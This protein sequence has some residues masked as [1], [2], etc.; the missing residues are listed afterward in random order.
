MSVA[1]DAVVIGAGHNGLVAAILLA[2]AGWSVT[3]LERNGEPGGAV[4]TEEVTVPGFKHDLFAMSLNAFIG[5]SFFAEHK[6]ELFA[7]GLALSTSAKPFGSIFPDGT[8]V[9]VSTRAEETLTSVGAVSAS[10]AESWRR[11][12]A[13]FRAYAPHLFATLATP[14]PSAAAAL[15]VLGGVRALGLKWP[16]D[17]TRLAAQ[18]SREF[19]EE[20]FER[21]ELHALVASWGMHLDFAPDLPGG[22]LFA[23]L[24]A[25]L[26]AEHGLAIG[27]GGARTVIDA[28]VSM[29]R[30]H[31]GRIV[32]GAD[33]ERIVVERGRAASVVAR[34]ERYEASRAVIAN[35]TPAGLF[36]RL[37]D[38][39]DLPADFR[40]SVAR[41]RFGPG[42][43]VI[44]LALDDL[45]PWRAG[46][47]VGEFS[48]VHIGPYLEDMGLAYQQAIAGL[49]PAEPMLVVG[50]P[51]AVD[52]TRAPEGKHVLWVMV[53]VVP[54]RIAGDAAGEIDARNWEKA[55]EPYADRAI[56]ILERYAPGLRD[57]ILGRFVMSPADLER[58]NPNLIGD[59]LGG[60]HHPMQNFFMRP[61]PGW[62]RY[63]TPIEG[64][65]MCGASTWPGAGTGAGSGYLLGKEL[66][67]PTLAARARRFFLAR[68]AAA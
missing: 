11:L 64:L 56:G 49:L 22:A 53:R 29:L 20:H 23:F 3:V 58:S 36:S 38:G 27:R 25:F 30:A 9:G 12:A 37:L 59:G 17:L 14:M 63:R 18:S 54:A 51:T 16:L 34:G 35:L 26:F 48:Y 2:K 19:V 15:A 33:A 45:P 31:G 62:S 43:L 47:A 44:H 52:P 60:S 61:F 67:R 40:R 24:N 39:V 65:Y 28:L 57:R 4:R 1:S 50:Q 6:D 7:H 10:D 5:S 66:T 21:P 13:R 55:K 41:Y 8:F 68:S 42:T 32:T 46:E